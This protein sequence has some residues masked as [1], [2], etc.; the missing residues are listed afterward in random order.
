MRPEQERVKNLLSDT[1]TLL[2]KNGLTYKGE[3]HIE[4]LIGITLDKSDVF[5]VHINER[6]HANGDK[7][8]DSNQSSDEVEE[9]SNSL[10]QKDSDTGNSASNCIKFTHPNDSLSTVSSNGVRAA[11]MNLGKGCYDEDITATPISLSEPNIFIKIEDDEIEVEEDVEDADQEE[12]LRNPDSVAQQ[13]FMVAGRR[14]IPSKRSHTS[15]SPQPH[16]STS[17]SQ[18]DQVEEPDSK[19][20]VTE[21]CKDDSVYEVVDSIGVSAVQP[22]QAYTGVSDYAMQVAQASFSDSSM[23]GQMIPAGCSSWSPSTARATHGEGVG[24]VMLCL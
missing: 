7:V 11:S 1:V 19:R 21:V 4:A 23:D 20:M 13:A 10:A 22:W 17:S 5:L 8:L 18:W 16:D 14:R 15:N 24:Y 6:F 9:E 3:L 2:C 12:H